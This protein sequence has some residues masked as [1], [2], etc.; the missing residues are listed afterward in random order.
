MYAPSQLTQRWYGGMKGFGESSRLPALH[1]FVISWLRLRVV[2]LFG[3]HLLMFKFWS[4]N[5]FGVS[6]IPAHS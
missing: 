3:N 2:A 5:S 4:D 6:A 1:N